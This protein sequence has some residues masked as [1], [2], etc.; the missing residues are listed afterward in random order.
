MISDVVAAA[1]AR[2]PNRLTDLDFLQHG[3]C[4]GHV[5]GSRR[6]SRFIHSDSAYIFFFFLN[7]SS[8]RATYY[9]KFHTNMI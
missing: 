2:Q 5:Y 1:R 6:W 4:D 3:L 7:T 9:L 8:M